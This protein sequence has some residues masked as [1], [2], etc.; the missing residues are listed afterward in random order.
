[1]DLEKI[2]IRHWKKL[3]RDL[4]S[5]RKKFN[6]LSLSSPKASFELL[7]SELMQFAKIQHSRQ[8]LSYFLLSKSKAIAWQGKRR[9][10]AT[11]L[12]VFWIPRLNRGMTRRNRA[13]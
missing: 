9:S 6:C 1:L 11:S 13:F 2:S 5:E 4:R 7:V 10:S 12:Q 8:F 3:G